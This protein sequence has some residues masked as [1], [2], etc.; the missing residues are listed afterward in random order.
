MPTSQSK[1]W[2]GQPVASCTTLAK[3]L[4]H[5]NRDERCHGPW[6]QVLAGGMGIELYRIVNF[7]FG[8]SLGYSCTALFASLVLSILGMIIIVSEPQLLLLR[9]LV[10]LQAVEMGLCNQV[11]EPEPPPRP[12]I[13]VCLSLLQI[14]WQSYSSG[15]QVPESR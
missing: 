3:T 9:M 2:K 8:P 12:F 7:F 10:A 13:L 15:V 4:V 11:R 5:S 14:L 6:R 1:Q